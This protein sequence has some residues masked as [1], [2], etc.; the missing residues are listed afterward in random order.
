MDLLEGLN[1][2]Q[3]EAVLHTEGAILIL[4]GAGSGKTRVLTH[5]IAYMIQKGVSPFNILAITFTNKA[6]KE[7]KERV[8][9]ISEEGHLVWVS[10]FHAICVRIL[11]NEIDKIGY[12]SNFNIYDSDDSE[13]IIKK[14]IKQLNINEKQYLPRPIMSTISTW[15]D[16]LKNAATIKKEVYD[17]FR[18]SQIAKVYE[19]Y[20]KVLV[21]N[22]ALDFDDII[23]KCVQL[24]IENEEVLKKY[25]DRFKYIMVDEYQDT[26]KSQYKLINILS[27]KEGNLCVVGDDDQSI[28]GWRGANIRNILDFEKDYKN[29]ISIKLE[30]NYRSSGTILEV[31]NVVIANNTGRKDKK[32]W[33]D[34]GLGAKINYHKARDDFE[35]SKFVIEKITENLSNDSNFKDHAI[36][37]RNNAQSRAI[38]DQLVKRNI[39]YKLLGGT[40][41]YER[42][43]IKDILSYLKFI[44]N[45]QDTLALLRVINVPKRGIGDTTIAKVSEY[46]QNNE[47]S[48][49][50]ALEELG[51]IEGLKNR[52]K[53]LE[54]FKN[55]MD[56]IISFSK[57]ANKVSDLIKHLIEEIGYKKELEDEK[58]EEAAGR[59]E[60]IEELISKAYEFEKT[61]EDK[62]L[63]SFLEEVALVADVDAYEQSD[64]YVVL[65][66]L[67]SSKGLEFNRV[68]VIG[69]EENIFPSYRAVTSGDSKD[70]EEERRLCYVGITR[71]KEVLCLTSASSRMQ[72][73]KVVYNSM[74]RFLKEI[75]TKFIDEISMANTSGRNR[76][77]KEAKSVYNNL[78]KTIGLG[79]KGESYLNNVIEKPKN[80]VIDFEV[81]DNVR[82]LKYG[83]GTVTDIKPAGADYEVTVNFKDVGN[84]KFMAHLSKLK[85]ADD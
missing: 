69:F 25:Q 61:A 17:D 16:E 21:E 53:K 14:C 1:K 71:A 10:T 18:L 56:E 77:F 7:M 28:Y 4:A 85:K 32:L 12:K 72:H 57:D 40:R 50:K 31:A 27:A 38:E 82:Q 74:S 62:S 11:R 36:L 44:N 24:L 54:N 46:S 35:E 39:P 83:V 55:I 48:F 64:D 60:N 9:N 29:S 52:A 49:Y 2:E 5:R 65:M 75:P 63:S 78:N 73:G 70:L 13:R 33:T 67:H 15:K 8:S 68:F 20:E 84:K 51:S 59:I 3:K 43:E 42:R 30:Q 22:N 80:V 66:T 26:N 76:S 47:V 23:F 41:F 34:K 19:L 6:A 79:N 37:Y 81:G 45:E 58:T